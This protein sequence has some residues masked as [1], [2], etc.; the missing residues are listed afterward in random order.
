MMTTPDT[1]MAAFNSIEKSTT[2]MTTSLKEMAELVT[3]EKATTKLAIKKR[4]HRCKKKRV[5]RLQMKKRHQWAVSRGFKILAN[6][7]LSTIKSFDL[8]KVMRRI[9]TRE[10]RQ[11]SH[12][13]VN[14]LQLTTIPIS[15]ISC[16]FREVRDTK[17]IAADWYV[18]YKWYGITLDSRHVGAI[19]HVNSLN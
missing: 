16:V 4:K 5:T 11:Q 3:N 8:G 9:S 12:S 1:E 6:Y 13:L 7:E 14:L 18:W 2:M 17:T 19:V 10:K 15:V